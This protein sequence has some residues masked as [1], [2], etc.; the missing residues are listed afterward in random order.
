MIALNQL[1]GRRR[2][3]NGTL[4][5]VAYPVDSIVRDG[6]RIGYIGRHANAHII[7][8]EYS[9]AE[10]KKQIL[11]EVEANAART[12]QYGVPSGLV[13]CPP[14]MTAAENTTELDEGDD[15]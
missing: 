13:T 11:A 2:E 12:A 5:E 1:T 9:D 4:I 14:D 15:G 8:L 6:K 7:L 3:C 10:R